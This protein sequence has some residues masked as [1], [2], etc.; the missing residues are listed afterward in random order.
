MLPSF[1]EFT[2]PLDNARVSFLISEEIASCV[3]ELIGLECQ[4]RDY[5]AMLEHK[6]EL[7]RR[8]AYLQ[9]MEGRL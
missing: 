9:G 1:R 2:T 7:E 3:M 8:I 6:A 5:Q 4:E